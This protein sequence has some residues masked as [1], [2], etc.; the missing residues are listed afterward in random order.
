MF[1]WV[2]QEFFC[3]FVNGLCDLYV[4]FSVNLILPSRHARTNI[5]FENSGYKLKDE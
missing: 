3:E 5:F 2:I 4:L 1:I